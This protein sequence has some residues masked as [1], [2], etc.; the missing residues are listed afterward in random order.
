M[1]D[2]R[3]P[4]RPILAVGAL[5]FQDNKIL[6]VERG[7][8]P[9][10]GYWSLPGG[11]VEAGEL[12]ETALLREVLEETG[13]LVQCDGL[14]EIFERI[15]PD[16][17]GRAEFHYV[18]AD[19]LCHPVGGALAAASDAT[20]AAWFAEDELAGLKLTHG[21]LPVIARAFARYGE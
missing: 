7:Q 12:L 2:R 16:G 17:D 5:I 19:Y 4:Q 11:A 18:I 1:S 6:L 8:E 21:S 10:R 9:L 15:T 3:Y 20:G 13:L 14:H